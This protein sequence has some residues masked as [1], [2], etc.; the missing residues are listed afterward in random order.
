MDLS[1]FVFVSPEGQH[2][3]ARAIY[4]YWFVSEDQISADHDQ[5]MLWMG[6]D[7]LRTGVLKRWAYIGCLGVGLPGQEENVYGRL[8]T[9]I[10]ASVPQFQLPASPARLPL[11]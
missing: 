10:A 2:L 8:K 7:M 4:V 11:K 1:K 3:V 6:L 5:R 9:L